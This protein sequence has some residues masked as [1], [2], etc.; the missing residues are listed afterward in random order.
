MLTK[1]LK[2]IHCDEKVEVSFTQENYE[3]HMMNVQCPECEAVG[4]F[5]TPE[6]NKFEAHVLEKGSL[7]AVSDPGCYPI[8]YAS[9]GD[10]LCADCATKEPEAIEAHSVHW[11]GAPMTCDRCGEEIE[12]AYGDP[13]EGGD[14]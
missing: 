4:F 9:L 1:E 10:C 6:L 11:E 8:Y 12:S 7:P 13:S 14:E 3:R 5:D 2:C